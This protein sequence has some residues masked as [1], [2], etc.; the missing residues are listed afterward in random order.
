MT[1]P[2]IDHYEAVRGPSDAPGTGQDDS[3]QLV[4]IDGH[5]YLQFSLKPGD[6]Q[7]WDQGEGN[8]GSNGK[9]NERAE[10]SLAPAQGTLKV[11]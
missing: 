8:R 7:P 6:V 11:Q 2:K 10:V 4:T 5:Q 9:F 3:I 1:Q